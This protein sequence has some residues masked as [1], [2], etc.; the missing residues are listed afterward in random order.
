MPEQSEHFLTLG[1]ATIR[2]V[3][4]GVIG[5][6]IVQ[7]LLAGI[8]FIVAD[9][10]G[11]GLFTFLVLLLA[12]SQVGCGILLIPMIVWYWLTRDT[13][14]ALLF[15]LYMVP[16]G[17]VDSVLKPFAMGHGSQTPMLVIFVGV[18][19][20]TLAH[21]LIGLFVGPI[22]LAVGWELLAAWMR[23]EAGRGVLVQEEADPE[24]ERAAANSA[25]PRTLLP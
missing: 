10:P 19:G 7:A 1:G 22:V 11:A 9:V 4:Q 15:T 18:L 14:S 24:A 20:G 2:A 6:A 23:D 21:G 25:E 5:V 3:A 17:F 12:I 16:V 8:G 13:S